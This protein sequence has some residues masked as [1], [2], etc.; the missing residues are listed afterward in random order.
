[1]QIKHL[2]LLFSFLCFSVTALFSQEAEEYVVLSVHKRVL[3]KMDG[4]F[5]KPLNTD[6]IF[7]DFSEL[8]FQDID[9]QVFYFGAFSKSTFTMGKDGKAIPVNI[10]GGDRL[11]TLD[12][13]MNGERKKLPRKFFQDH[14]FNNKQGP[15]IKVGNGNN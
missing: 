5:P 8:I 6:D 12:D 9:A 3:K 10:D 14:L 2:P 1:M 4:S 15:E 13:F 11:E 7:K